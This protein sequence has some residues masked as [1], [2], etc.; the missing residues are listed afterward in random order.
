MLSHYPRSPS[1]NPQSP[2]KQAKVPTQPNM[3]QRTHSWSSGKDLVDCHRTMAPPRSMRRIASRHA[4]RAGGHS[5][6]HHFVTTGPSH[7]LP[8]RLRLRAGCHSHE[9]HFATTGP[10]LAR[11]GPEDSMKDRQAD[12]R[13]QCTL[14]ISTARSD[15]GPN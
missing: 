4:F 3:R 13:K 14:S 7:C 11:V 2:W 1:D 9:H 10:S 8:I 15:D 6:E 12:G 5:H